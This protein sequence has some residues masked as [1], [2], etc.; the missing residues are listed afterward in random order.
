MI[1]IIAQV[2]EVIKLSSTVAF[3]SWTEGQVTSRGVNISD[4]R[5]KGDSV[6][7]YH[8]SSCSWWINNL[9]LGT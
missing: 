9:E 3:Q 4:L 7:A 2:L 1:N 8:H 5:L 6:E